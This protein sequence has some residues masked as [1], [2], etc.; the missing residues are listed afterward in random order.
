[1]TR[2]SD[3]PDPRERT[4][5]RKG[6]LCPACG[7]I[8]P[9]DAETVSGR[10]GFEVTRCPGCGEEYPTTF[11]Q[12]DFVTAVTER[13]RSA[14]AGDLSEHLAGGGVVPDPASRTGGLPLTAKADLAPGAPERKLTPEKAALSTL[15]PEMQMT[16]GGLTPKDGPPAVTGK[17]EMGREGLMVSSIPDAP[18]GPASHVGVPAGDIGTPEPPG[19]DG[20][21]VKKNLRP[22]G[23]L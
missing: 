12:E 14:G 2:E 5:D 22:S 4:F 21:S 23:P 16:G 3:V 13:L 1:M 8:I 11:R 17:P 6:S 15:G 19:N 10:E 9:A 20:P 18:K 7:A